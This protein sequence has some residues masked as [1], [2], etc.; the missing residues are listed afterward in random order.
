MAK[1]TR[2]ELK[3]EIAGLKEQV[4]DLQFELEETVDY[5]RDLEMTPPDY[6]GLTDVVFEAEGRRMEGREF[7]PWL[8]KS[9]RRFV[10][11]G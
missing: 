6:D 4:A 8:L 7:G 11:Y 10:S 9:V 1:R 3:G 5:A 2:A